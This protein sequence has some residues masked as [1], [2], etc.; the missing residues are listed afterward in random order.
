MKISES[1]WQVMKVLW[2]T[3]NLTMKEIAASLDRVDWSY[4]TVRTLVNRLSDKG[5]L[6]ADRS[7]SHNFKYSPAVSEDE[8]QKKEV[9]SLLARVF[10]GS[11]SMLVS[12]LTKD[13]NLSEEEQRELMNLIEKM[14]QGT[15][16]NTRKG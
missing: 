6:R 14:D 3:P 10:N 13:S 1:E 2:E 5:A 9:R 4:T 15:D 7:V 12:T 16:Q 11:V 8:C